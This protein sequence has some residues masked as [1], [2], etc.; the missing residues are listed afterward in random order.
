MAFTQ[1]QLEALEIAISS[2]T[3]TV[4]YSD[5]RVTYQDLDAMLKLRAIMRQELGLTGSSKR[6]LAEFKKGTGC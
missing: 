3:L 5:K 6:I 4:E 1:S 2:G